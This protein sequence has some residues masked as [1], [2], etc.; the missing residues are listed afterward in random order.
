MS[1]QGAVAPR[2]GT[3][4]LERCSNHLWIRQDI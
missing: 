1:P 4:E 3:T 2:L